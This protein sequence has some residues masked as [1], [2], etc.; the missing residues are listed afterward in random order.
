MAD[1]NRIMNG[2]EDAKDATAYGEAIV[3]DVEQ[4][5]G[6]DYRMVWT[7]NYAGGYPPVEGRRE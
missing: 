7:Q 6:D 1:I 4:I 3:L 5:D 2:Y